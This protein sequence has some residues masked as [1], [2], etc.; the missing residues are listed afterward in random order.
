M[1]CCRRTLQRRNSS[2]NVRD[3]NQNNFIPS[4]VE[5]FNP[6]TQTVEPGEELVFLQTNYNT[7]ASFSTR[8]DGLGVDIVS[9]G[10]YKISFSGIATSSE[11]QTVSLGISLN[12]SLFPQSEVSQ[13]VLAEGPEI[14]TTSLIFKV[15]SP[16]ADIGVIVTGENGFSIQNAKL[17][18]VRIGNV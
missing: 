9:S 14:I 1:A 8:F 15:I 10:V 5:V 18:I 6:T 4:A 12:G 2:P 17:D 13:L 16:S 11:T 3:F 7:G